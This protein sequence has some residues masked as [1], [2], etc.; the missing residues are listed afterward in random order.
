M[1]LLFTAALLSFVCHAQTLNLPSGPQNQEE[2]DA[3]AVQNKMRTEPR[4]A[5]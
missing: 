3:F 4:A 1:K 2:R 5:A